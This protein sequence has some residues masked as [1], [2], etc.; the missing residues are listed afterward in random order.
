MKKSTLT[1]LSILLTGSVLIFLF[2]NI[3]STFE[4]KTT[5][6]MASVFFKNSIETAEIVERFEDSK[7]KIMIVPGHDNKNFG[8]SFNGVIEA[9]LNLFVAKQ[10]VSL[11]DEEKN[12]ETFLTRDDNGYNKTLQKYLEKEKGSIKEFEQSKKEIMNDL[13]QSGK[14]EGYVNVHHNAARPEVVDILYGINK[15]ANDN[16]FDIVFHIHFN[17]YPGRRGNSG[18]YSGFSLY[19]PEKQYSNSDASIDLAEKIKNQLLQISAGSNLPLED[20][21]IVEDQEL[22]AV[23]A[24]N[25]ADP[26]AVLVEYGYIY[27]SQFTDN[28]IGEIFL[29]ELANQTYFGIMNYLNQEDTSLKTFEL[30]A[31]YQ[32]QRDLEKGDSGVDVLALQD[33]LRDRGYYPYR[34]NM[35]DCPMNGHFG[36]C[37]IS[38]LSMYQH[39][40]GLDSTGYFGPQTREI[41]NNGHYFSL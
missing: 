11:L 18:K 21:V 36:K 20:A 16:E 31:N 32:W 17:D 28:V 5:N 4:N 10:L 19:V 25:T 39:S 41:F 26:V 24:Y 13:V 8:A 23:G 34:S 3:S 37:T 33:F 2:F 38:A 7:V 35:N 27:E 29:N 15:Y 40:K 12:V 22:I 9:D 6:M 1:F 14:V 30:F